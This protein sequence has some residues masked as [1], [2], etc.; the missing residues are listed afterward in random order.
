VGRAPTAKATV[1]WAWFLEGALGMEERKLGEGEC[2]YLVNVNAMK[3]R[4]QEHLVAIQLCEQR[5]NYFMS[6]LQREWQLT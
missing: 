4:E 2:G 1:L 5:L 3:R 6:K